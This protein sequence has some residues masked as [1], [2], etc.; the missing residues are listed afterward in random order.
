MYT[1]I[2]ILRMRSLRLWSSSFDDESEQQAAESI[3]GNIHWR[4]EKISR[5]EGV[6]IN[7]ILMVQLEYEEFEAFM[8]EIGKSIGL[9]GNP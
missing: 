9:G 4:P 8:K 5:G 6:P 2:R 1:L 3:F 7:C